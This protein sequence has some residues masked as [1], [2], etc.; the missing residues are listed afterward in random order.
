MKKSVFNK[1]KQNTEEENKLK[2]ETVNTANEL[3]KLYKEYDAEYFKT[4]VLTCLNES[5]T[6]ANF[7][8]LYYSFDYFK[9][10]AINEVFKLTNYEELISF[11]EN[12]DLFAMNLNNVIMSGVLLFDKEDVS[13]V[14]VKKYRLSK[15]NIVDDDLHVDNIE[16]MINKI[17]LLLRINKI[18]HS[19]TTVENIWFMTKA[20][21]INEN[22]ER[23]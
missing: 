16:N 8:E 15:I 12:F 4:T 18:E 14:I 23:I 13:N 6:I 9:K 22:L 1:K 5:F 11:S 21:E 20:K 10:T 7:L 19:Q 17:N 2:I 3:Y